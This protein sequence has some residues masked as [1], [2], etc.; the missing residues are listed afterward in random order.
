[1]IEPPRIS[2]QSRLFKRPASRI[3]RGESSGF[4]QFEQSRVRL[5]CVAVFFICC[6]AA[7]GLR[8]IEVSFM[9]GGELPFKRLVTEPQLL[10]KHEEQVDKAHASQ[11]QIMRRDITD[12]NGLLIATSVATASLVANPTLIRHEKEVA[13]A[14]KSI[15]PEQDYEVLLKHLMQKRSKFIYIKRHLKPS[16]QEA[17]NNLGV[18]GLFFEP[19]TKR[20]YPYGALFSHVL[21][22]V[23]VDNQGLAGIEKQFESSLSDPVLSQQPLTLSLDLRVQSMLHDELYDAYKEYS[24]I[25]ATGIVY[26]IKKGEILAMSNL[27]EFDANRPGYGDPKAR[28]NAA[29]LGTYEMGSTFKTFTVAAAIDAGVTKIDGGYDASQPIH[30]AGFTISDSHP[31][32][33]WLSVPEIFAYSSNIGTVHMAMELGKDKQQGFLKKLGMFEPVSIELPERSRPQYPKEWG[34]ISTMTVSFGHGISVS[35]LHVIEGI[36]SV[37]NG[38]NKA[39][40]TLLK[41][42]NA[43]RGVGE[44]IISD[45][46]SK[47]VRQLLRLVVEHGTARSADVKGYRVGGKTGTAEKI[48]GGRYDANKK[49]SSFIGAFPMDDPGYLVLIMIDEPKG[50]KATYG[51]ATGGWV[52]APAAGKLIERMAPMLGVAPDFMMNDHQVD[53]MWSRAEMREKQEEIKRLQRIGQQG[54]V[55]AASF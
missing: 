32:N 53:A 14:L 3:V 35:P 54:G 9:G 26:D 6:F 1:M 20:V 39:Y 28:F 31:K 4:R 52:A 42:G 45:A 24:A 43:K 11:E 2:R 13:H 12:R 30:A 47:Q 25:G 55:H 15:F 34:Q 48:V 37:V 21:G 49:I 23:G 41:E 36:A 27:P 16:E 51:Y 10:L 19:D 17:V 18:P 40:L 8:L 7:L 50:T 38:G 33:C 5:L 46:T 22:Y 29:S 44:K